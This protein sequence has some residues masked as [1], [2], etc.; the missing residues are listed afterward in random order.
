MK[1]L[2]LVFV[3]LLVVHKAWSYT[4]MALNMTH[5]DHPGKCYYEGSD[6][7]T[8]V[9]PGEEVTIKGRCT[10]AS[11]HSDFSM[12]FATCGLI[13][14]PKEYFVPGNL[15]LPYPECC[16]SFRKRKQDE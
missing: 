15:S 10:R 13:L 2:V 6:P 11:C 12:N 9:T 3:Q 14:G 4:S 8:I 16:P 5:P 7:P 1:F